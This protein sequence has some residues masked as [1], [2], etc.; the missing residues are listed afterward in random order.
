MVPVLGIPQPMTEIGVGLPSRMV[1]GGMA[2][3]DWL[4]PRKIALTPRRNS[5]TL[6]H[7]ALRGPTGGVQPISVHL[8]RRRVTP[9]RSVSETIYLLLNP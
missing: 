1:A 7:R 3:S 2:D 5:A 9:C 8:F 6:A 4:P